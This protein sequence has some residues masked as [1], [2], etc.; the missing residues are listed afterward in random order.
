MTRRDW[1]EAVLSRPFKF[2]LRAQGHLPTVERM[3][4]DGATWVEIGKEIGWCPV[5]AEQWYQREAKETP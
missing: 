5:T 4:A 2:G 1:L 3:L